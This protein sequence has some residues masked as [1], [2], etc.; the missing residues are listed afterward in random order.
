MK[1]KFNNREIELRFDFNSDMVFETIMGKSFEQKTET[2]WLTYFYCTYLIL[3]QDY[4]LAWTDCV[5]M[6][7]QQ[8]WILWQFVKWY[9]TYMQNMQKLIPKPEEEQDE[10]KKD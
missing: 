3:T 5:Q 1:I 10:L 6:L 7:S 4:E 8:P 9:T 2:E